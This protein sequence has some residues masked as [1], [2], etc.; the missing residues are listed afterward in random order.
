MSALVFCIKWPLQM[1]SNNLLEP[2]PVSNAPLLCVAGG[3]AQLNRSAL[4]S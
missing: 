3:A 1:A 4:R 2:T